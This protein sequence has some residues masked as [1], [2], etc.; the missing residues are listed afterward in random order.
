MVHLKNRNLVIEEN[1]VGEAK[2]CN[3]FQQV[4]ITLSSNQLGNDKYLFK[5][6]NMEEE[7]IKMFQKSLILAMKKKNL[8]F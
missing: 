6:A 7:E 8:F 1:L 2:K 5:I 4:P 3:F